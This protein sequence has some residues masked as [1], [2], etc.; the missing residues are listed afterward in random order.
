MIVKP[1]KTVERGSYKLKDGFDQLAIQ[2]K[3]TEFDS[4]RD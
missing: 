3:D 1:K 4:I 2:H